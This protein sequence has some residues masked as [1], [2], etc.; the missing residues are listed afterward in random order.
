MDE[1]TVTGPTKFIKLD[2]GLIT[3]IEVTPADF[4]LPIHDGK[5]LSGGNA[6]QNATALLELLKGKNSVYM[7]IVLMNCSAVLNIHGSV[8]NLK[9]GVIMA[10]QE[11]D[12]G[13]ALDVLNK[14]KLFSQAQT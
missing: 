10:A 8:T 7:D 6:F 1:I 12:N 11:I 14:Y 3:E 13:N 9:D 2:N 4:G 5:E